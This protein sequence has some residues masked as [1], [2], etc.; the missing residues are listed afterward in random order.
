[1]SPLPCKRRA[2][3]EFGLYLINI[4]LFASILLVGCP[5]LAPADRASYDG[6]DCR[7]GS[8]EFTPFGVIEVR[9][10]ELSGVGARLAN[11]PES[12]IVDWGGRHACEDAC[13]TV[14]V[15]DPRQSEARWPFV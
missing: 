12:R 11:A 4:K 6:A 9:F 3:A 13:A 5:T 14:F 8:R 7:S 15:C 2:Y 10:P 1:M